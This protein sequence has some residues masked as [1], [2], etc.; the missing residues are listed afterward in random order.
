MK[1]AAIFTTL[2]V[3]LLWA[4]TALAQTGSGYDLTWFTVDGGGGASSG[5]SYAL[6]GTVGQ[7]DAGA[8]SNGTYS[9]VG[10]FWTSVPSPHRI[11]LP[12][13]MKN[14]SS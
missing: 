8:L 9:L 13:V 6:S 14:A 2:L 1:R 12:V 10:G 7:P 11:Y 5:S 3:S 4:L